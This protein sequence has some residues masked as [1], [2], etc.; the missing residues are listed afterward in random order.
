MASG[1]DAL[2]RF[3]ITEY[4]QVGKFIAVLFLFAGFL[5]SI[6]VFREFRVP[7]TTIGLGRVRSE[8]AGANRLAAASET[9]RAAA[10][11]ETTPS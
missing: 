11:A 1:G 5:V 9:S 6:E 2:N 3:G 8:P 10:V 4:F 7:F